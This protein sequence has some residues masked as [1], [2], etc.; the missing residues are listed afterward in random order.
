[1]GPFWSR[2]G[3]CLSRY[4]HKELYDEIVKRGKDVNDF[5]DKAAEEALEREVMHMEK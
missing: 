4:L 3:L 1:M 2:A 5:V